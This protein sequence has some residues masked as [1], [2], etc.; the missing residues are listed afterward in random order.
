MTETIIVRAGRG[1]AARPRLTRCERCG[2]IHLD[3]CYPF[4]RAC[5]V[6]GHASHRTLAG[7]VSCGYCRN[8]AT[9]TRHTP[10]DG[11]HYVLGWPNT[12]PLQAPLSPWQAAEPCVLATARRLCELAGA[13]FDEAIRAAYPDDEWGSPV[14]EAAALDAAL[15]FIDWPELPWPELRR[16]VLDDLS[17]CDYHG[18]AAEL[19][20]RL[21][22]GTTPR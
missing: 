22:E 4:T 13:D 19:D 8:G 20:D 1:Y 9:A 2:G 7:H 18:L 14:E 17:D 5:R 15:A 12:E 10:G 6:A 3:D 11:W 21:P 16:R